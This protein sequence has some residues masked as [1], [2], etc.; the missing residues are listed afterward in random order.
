MLFNMLAFESTI[1]VREL[2][3]TSTETGLSIYR[4]AIVEVEIGS[5]MGAKGRS[6]S[7]LEY[8]FL[9]T[10]RWSYHKAGCQ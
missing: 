5:M 6:T 7:S 9:G 8:L 2:S 3:R 1:V 10:H 4:G